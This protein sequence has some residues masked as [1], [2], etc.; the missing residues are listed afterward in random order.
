MDLLGVVILEV[1]EAGELVN[2]DLREVYFLAVGAPKSDDIRT[3][4]AAFSHPEIGRNLASHFIRAVI[5]A[6]GDE[7]FSSAQVFAEAEET[8]KSFEECCV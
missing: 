2:R 6:A 4:R 3:P 1:V 7:D 5:A 8:G